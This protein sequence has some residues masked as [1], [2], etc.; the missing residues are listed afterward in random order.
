MKSRLPRII[1]LSCVV[2]I[3]LGVAWQTG[4]AA[5]PE[6][7]P[8]PPLKPKPYQVGIAPSHITTPTAPLF[9]ERAG[10]WDEVRN[11]IDL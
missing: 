5:D 11:N 2:F 10:D 6:Q 8:G 7:A 4:Y 9:G 1:G 3:S